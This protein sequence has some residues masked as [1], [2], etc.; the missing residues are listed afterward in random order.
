M[1]S[2]SQEA[3]LKLPIQKS[4]NR[5]VFYTYIG[6]IIL[7]LFSAYLVFSGQKKQLIDKRESQVE[8]HVVQI[9]M[10]LESSLRA[11][12]SI[13]AL[14]EGHVQSGQVLRAS[15]MQDFLEYDDSTNK[16]FSR[17]FP[18]D[19]GDSL[20]NMGQISGVGET[21][22]RDDSF[23]LELDMMFDMAMAFPIAKETAPKASS[24][25]YLSKNNM[26]VNYPEKSGLSFRPQMLNQRNFLLA[27]PAQNPTRNMFWSEAYTA[28]N[29]KGLMTTIGVPVYNKNEFLGSINLEMTLSSLAWQIRQYFRM[30][31]TVI[32]LDQANNILSHSDF[33]QDDSNRIYHL[34]QRIPSEL[35]SIPE[36]ELVDAKGGMIRNNYFIHAVPLDNAPWTLL[37]IQPVEDLYQDAWDKLESSFFMVVIAL[38][39]LVTIVHWLTRRTFVSPAS[40]LLTHLEDCAVEPQEPPSKVDP[41]WR[42]WFQLVS[43]IFEEH[44]QYN[45]HLS[46]QNKRLDA[47]VAERTA[48]LKQ[49][50]E[51]RERDFALLRSLIDS[52]PEAISF[53]DPEGRYLGCNKSAERMIGLSENEIIGRRAS[54]FD[55]LDNSRETLEDEQTV[56]QSLTAVRK[57]KQMEVAGKQ[58]LFDSLNM[59]FTNRRGELLGLISIWRDVTREHDAA[60]QLRRSE[61]RY[62]LAMGA[63]EDGLW[64]WYLDSEQIICNDTYY[65]ML[66]FKPGEFPPLISALEGLIHPDD[67]AMREQIVDEFMANPTGAFEAEYRVRS[68]SG[69]YLWL[70]ARGRIVEF[71]DTGVPVRMVGTH[72]DITRQKN[73]EEDLLV[74]K[75]EAESANLYKSEFL[76]NMSHEIRTPMNAI[77][78][79]LQ[80]AQRTPLTSQQKDYLDKAGF[81]AQSLLR[82]INDI[83]DFSKIEAGKLELESVDFALEQVLEHAIN[84]NALN[85]QEKGVELLLHAPQAAQL[86]LMGDPLRLGQVLINLLS[87]AVKFTSEGE[88]E[89]GCE[90]VSKDAGQTVLKLWVRDTGVGIH[91]H[92]QKRL[93]EAFSQ[94]DGSTT[95][96]Y[97]GTGL[98]LSICRHL[99]ALMGG[100]MELESEPGQG[101]TFFFQLP[102]EIAQNAQK[103]PLVVPSVLNDLSVLVVDDNASAAEIYGHMLK[104]FH[105]KVDSASSG[106]QALYKLAKQPVD[107][108]LLDWMMPEM[109]GLNVVAELENLV[110]KGQIKRRPKIIMMTAYTA[111]PLQQ[112]VG[113]NG[114]EALLQKPI[115]S[116]SLLDNI[117]EVFNDDKP[118]KADEVDP[119]KQ[120]QDVIKAELLLVEDNIINQQVACELLR[121]SGYA[122][123][124]ADNGQIALQMVSEKT[125]Q[126]V[127]MDIQ[128]PVM[129]GLTATKEL[130]KRYS[131]QELPV[132]AMTAHAMSGDKEKSLA[133]GMNDHIT[134]PIVLQ[135]LF[136]T[137]TKHIKA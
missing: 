52:I 120:P 3:Q 54:D 20:L 57:L 34:S 100:S 80:L 103:A 91:K 23:Y 62:Q 64:D 40:R 5:A 124:V 43:R 50:T 42:P 90:V 72:K 123:D 25:Y 14:A 93:F 122:V 84:L 116:S 6:V 70:L 105:F 33:N 45:L 129:D 66:G 47:L 132:I 46:E 67:V 112:E 135:Q 51:R 19:H 55:S 133:A 81:S 94:A 121:S 126:A 117:I 49:T 48:S 2:A 136:D 60:E 31:G 35:H 29:S 8:Q 108:L 61:E 41:G 71:S 75:Q 7:A 24:I 32:L 39:I 86:H 27:A 36:A 130:R 26:M 82:I 111:E 96:E 114:V 28:P 83:L 110:A 58:M 118:T 63:V 87:N 9:D 4:Y 69:E 137:L 73:N 104:S 13:K 88:I 78:G 56:L 44:Q 59:P 95:R 101:S 89:L 85:A 125:Y 15:R 134:K 37:Y 119:D 97:G 76:A 74:A 1:N 98:G 113:E 10:L 92:Q 21:L 65:T 22:N 77:I 107:L 128:M 99:V 30:Q 11:I 17:K 79:M 68:K 127:L 38:S 115:K 53:K 109:D 106:A 102:F 12:T 18:L 131:A 16:F